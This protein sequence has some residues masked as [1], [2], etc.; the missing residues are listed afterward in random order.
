[1]SVSAASA[2]SSVGGLGRR[3]GAGRRAPAA[4]RGLGA[5][6]AAPEQ[7]GP[8]AGRAGLGAPRGPGVR[9]W[10][11][12]ARRGGAGRADRAPA[13]SPACPKP[14]GS[15]A[16]RPRARSPS[17]ATSD[18]G[19]AR[20]M[21]TARTARGGA[22]ARPGRTA[23]PTARGRTSRGC[24]WLRPSPRSFARRGRGPCPLHEAARVCAIARR[25]AAHWYVRAGWRESAA[26]GA[27][28]CAQPARE[29]VDARV[30]GRRARRDRLLQ[31]GRRARCSAAA[32]RT[33]ARCR[34][35]EWTRHV[36]PVRRRRQ[37]DPVR[38][39]RRSP[40]PLRAQP[41]RRTTASRSAR[42][43]AGRAADRGER[44][45][46]HGRGRLPRRD[47]GVLAGRERRP[48]EAA[49]LGRARIG[50][51]RPDRRR[52][53]T[54][55]TP[56]ACRSR[57][58]TARSSCSTPARASAASASRCRAT[59]GPLH[60][61]LTHLHLDHIQGLMFFAPMFRAGRR[62]RHLRPG[63]AA[64]PDASL[65]D[66]LARYISAAADAR[67]RS[68]SCPCHMSFREAEPD[69]VA[70]RLG[71]DRAPRPSRTAARRSA[72]GSPRATAAI[73][74]IPDHE[75]GLGTPL[76]A[77]EDEW[78]SGLELARGADAAA[79]RRPVHR[80]RVP[81]PPRLG[82]LLDGRRPDVRPPR[83]RRALLAFHHD[84]LHTD[85]ALDAI[86][87]EAARRGGWRRAARRARWPWRWRSRGRCCRARARGRPSAL[88]VVSSAWLP[89]RST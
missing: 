77:L 24:A 16:T 62:D 22:P 42:S 86:G 10:L 34:A 83:R 11:A 31:R 68:A 75:P 87:A 39:A 1:M 27:D 8:E 81:A 35:D 18:S 45:A 82:A 13:A 48:G 67:S 28:P 26:A 54:A 56:R 49:R 66:R 5:G 55:A 76:D 59:T 4:V 23:R 84:P 19:S 85:A 6:A 9:L 38:R 80:R 20:A 88:I 61:L 44:A 3:R 69:G 36:R 64:P 41:A 78:I 7:P 33:R 21:R 37:P 60:I 15:S 52:C 46:D 73:V 47:G 43:T 51:R 32:T 2:A 63:G 50:A 30:P 58:P 71:H 72:T 12:T 65:R 40:T 79:A 29:P 17:Q 25:C 57:S 14:D 70:D 74:Y 89:V 53:A